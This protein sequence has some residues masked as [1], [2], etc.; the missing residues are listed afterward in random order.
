MT[1]LRP[2]ADQKR[3]AISELYFLCCGGLNEN[4]HH[5]LINVNGWS[6]VECLWRIR[7]YGLAGGSVLSET[8]FVS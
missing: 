4:S 7:R 1:N 8:G 6:L 5:G 3:F 2:I